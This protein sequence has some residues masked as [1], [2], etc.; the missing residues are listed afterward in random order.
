MSGAC[1]SWQTCWYDGRM[2]VAENPACAPC[3]RSSPKKRFIGGRWVEAASGKTVGTVDPSNGEVL[4]EV[5]EGD[6]EDVNRAV[7]AARASF[8]AGSW[9]DLPPAERARILWKVG[10]LIE[11]RAAEFAELDSLDNGKP[12]NEML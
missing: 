2:A 12:I 11:E 1:M 3:L 9:R 10:D 8:E 6:R 7:A 5:A 4:A